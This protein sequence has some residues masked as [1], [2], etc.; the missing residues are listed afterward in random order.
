[1]ELGFTATKLV[2]SQVPCNLVSGDSSVLSH[3]VNKE[4][5][6]RQKKLFL[7]DTFKLIDYFDL[8]TMAP[9]GGKLNTTDCA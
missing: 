4:T 1:M 2:N 8:I 5:A 7:S 9:K 6:N 3:D